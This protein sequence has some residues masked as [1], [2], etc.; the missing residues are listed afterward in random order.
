[1]FNTVSA[2]LLSDIDAISTTKKFTTPSAA[3]KN[4]NPTPRN[5]L[6]N[7]AERLAVHQRERSLYI[8]FGQIVKYKREK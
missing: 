6:Q 2:L 5:I 1:M 3:A 7:T 4:A 8:I